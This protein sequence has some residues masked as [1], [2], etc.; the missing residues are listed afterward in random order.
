MV[1]FLLRTG[2]RENLA[3]PPIDLFSY[4]FLFLVAVTAV[5][6]FVRGSLA[7]GGTLL[8]VPLFVLVLDPAEAILIGLILDVVVGLPLLPP[9][10]SAV[11]WKQVSPVMA[12]YLVTAPLG[13]FVLYYTDPDIIRI[14]IAMV[15][16]ISGL[17]LLTGWGFRGRP[18]IPGSV[19]VGG[20]SGFF[21]TAAGIGGPILVLYLVAGKATA[22][23]TRANMFLM[24]SVMEAFSALAVL[25][26]A[27]FVIK[28]WLVLVTLL[29]VMMLFAYAGSK[30][31]IGISDTLFRRLV[32]WFVV[33]FGVILIARTLGSF[34]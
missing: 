24:S 34:F 28:N 2:G 6:G 32:I 19:A 12:G 26:G 14:A 30:A 4:E 8:M 27:A 3:E 9:L 15:V 5:G 11:N 29:P 18:T 20:T 23:E 16:V 33:V 21:G 17:L 13:A 10:I 31:V 25:A 1:R 22:R 7:F